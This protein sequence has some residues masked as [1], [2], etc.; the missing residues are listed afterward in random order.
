MESDAPGPALDKSPLDMHWDV[1]PG[2]E[3]HVS[4]GECWFPVHLDVQPG[5]CCLSLLSWSQNQGD[6]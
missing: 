3:V 4:V 2:Q 1:G 6:I 5:C